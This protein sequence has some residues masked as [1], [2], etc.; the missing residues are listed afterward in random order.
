MKDSEKTKKQF[1]NELLDFRKKIAE[2]ENVKTN[3]KKTEEKL[4][5]SEELYRLIAENTSDVIT[6]QDFN[7][8]AV[9]RYVSPSTKDAGGYEPEDLLGKSPFKFIHPDDKKKLFPILK[10]YV[11]NKLK[12]IF[13]GKELPTSKRIEFRF[14]HKEGNWRYLQ[15]VVNIVGNKLLFITRDITE[16]KKTEEKIKQS[17]EKYRTLFEN[18][19]GVYYRADKKGNVIMV[20]P[21]GVKL[22][23]Y[24]SSKEI[25]GKN[26]AKDLYYVPEDR[27]IFLEELKKR[28]GIVNDYE[29]TLKKREG[30]P[31]IVSTSSHYYYD[32]EG[33]IAG[34]EGIFLDITERKKIME[35][36]E[37]SKEKYRLLLENQTDLVV[38]VD[39][40]GK[41]LFVS[42]SYCE[43]F[44]KTEE[45]LL[46]NKFM[47]LVHEDDRE[48]T[49]KTMENLYKPPYTCYIEQRAKTKDG[50]RWL[51]WADKAVLDKDGKV[52][53]I[54]GV[55]RDITKRKQNEKLQQVLYNIS[56]A[57]NS[58]I[59]LDQLYKTIHQE[60]GTIIDT[61]NFHIALL[62]KY[63]NIISFDYFFDE[64]DDISVTLEHNNTGSLSAHVI[65]TG[66]PLL[67]N[68][69]QINKM[70]ERGELILSHLG[71]L[72]E[73][74]LWLGVPLK[75]EGKVIG[76]MA[77]LSYANPELYTQ[78]DIKIMEFVSNQVATAIKRKQDEE[79]LNKSQQEFASLFKNIPEALVYTDKENDILYVNPHFTEIFG[80]T[81]DE[82]KGKNID[83]GIIHTKEKIDE[84]KYYS[85]K[86]QKHFVNYESYRKR[87]DGSIF[88]VSISASSIKIDNKV[89]GIITLYQD[90]TE[91]KK[92]DN[93]QKVLYNISKAA[94]SPIS[95]GQLYP[96]IHKELG[97]IIDT[98]NF[99]I[100][101][102]DYQKDE[103]YFPYFVDEKDEDF[104][105]INFSETNSLTVYVIKTDQ[106]LL[107]DYKKVQKMIAQREVNVVGSIT[108]KTIWLGVPLKVEDK[109]IGAMAV[110]SYTNPKLYS[111]KDIEIMEFVSNQVATAI[112]R[113]RMEEELK[114]LAH[115]D[116]L[117][118]AYNR[119]YGL[120]LL[121]RQLKLSKRDKSPLLLA[122]SD[123]DNLKDI[124]DEFGHEEGDKA[125][126][127]V[128]K[129]FKS[130]LREVDIITRMGGDEFLVIFL[131]S[132]LNEIPIIKKRLSKELTRLNQVSKKPYKIGF[133]IGFSNYD[134]ANPQPMDELIRIADQMMYEE[135]K[136]KA[137][138]RL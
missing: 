55:G 100:A 94:N 32:K 7:L 87:K 73:E 109:V 18:M 46:G 10:N 40:E 124:N 86:S 6:L 74:T 23:G 14:K 52:V 44:G 59:T 110:Q 105:V 116:T 11:N 38:K 2:L 130:I 42:P 106:P 114:R 39:T 62:N 50:W 88:P 119:G 134:P 125:M 76:T 79:A 102:T 5:K 43:S 70:I 30:T 97:N 35:E 63:E 90:I 47:P 26:L 112:E 77:V 115:Y 61:T 16:S 75:I 24:N 71:T 82:I 67:V 33:N 56:K 91:R 66:R 53:A 28:K 68:R 80:Y 121:Q 138:G 83:E 98:T 69:Q 108:D 96:I 72:T 81:S 85:K 34:V 48:A 136:R 13:T 49:A 118:G 128:A 45:E 111:E 20:N 64:K 93:L 65:K 84:G 104:T 36:L 92:N 37:E 17:E 31:V 95:L 122:Y 120:E 103:I 127:Q 51:A 4:A 12:K 19:P 78:K 113:K 89:K 27:K 60:L 9:Y 133:S 99:F 22:L 1:V 137:K 57:A 135:K 132:S 29:V 129:L 101:L 123:L 41:F 117:T 54:V 25:I 15:S 126:V 107:V 21:P 131:D 3:H 8:R 58:P